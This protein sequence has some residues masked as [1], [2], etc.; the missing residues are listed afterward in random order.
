MGQSESPR[1][2]EQAIEA[3]IRRGEWPKRGTLPVCIR[4]PQIAVVPPVPTVGASDQPTG[5]GSGA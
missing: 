2:A 4:L 1:P 3:F 5:S